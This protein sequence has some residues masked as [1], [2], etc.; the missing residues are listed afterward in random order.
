MVVEG[1]LADAERK[2]CRTVRDRL[3]RSIEAFANPVLWPANR[4]IPHMPSYA[5][6]NDAQDDAELVLHVAHGL[7]CAAH[8]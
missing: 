2:P 3:L 5:M 7:S 8:A 1:A 4:I 6:F